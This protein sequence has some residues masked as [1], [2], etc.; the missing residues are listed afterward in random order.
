MIKNILVSLFAVALLALPAATASAA[1][2]APEVRYGTWVSNNNHLPVT[3]RDWSLYRNNV[4]VTGWTQYR[5]HW[6][7]FNNAGVMQ[8]GWQQLGG[9]W[10]FLW[11]QQDGQAP[12]G[13]ML[14]NDWLRVGTNTYYAFGANGVMLTGV[15]LLTNPFTGDFG[16]FFFNNDGAMQRGW[17]R[18]N[19]TD[20][21][22]FGGNGVRRSGIFQTSYGVSYLAP[23]G[24]LATG[25]TSF[26]GAWHYSLAN[27]RLQADRWVQTGGVWYRLVGFRMLANTAWTNA[28]NQTFF[29]AA[30]G[31]MRTGWVQAGSQWTWEA[32]AWIWPDD[33]LVLEGQWFYTNADGVMQTGWQQIGG[34]WFY[35]NRPEYTNS[36]WARGVMLTG[37]VMIYGRWHRFTTAGRWIGHFVHPNQ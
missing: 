26:D 31:A 28:N 8:T 21:S 10:F 6:Y 32:G 27:G 34:Q 25:W 13:A 33:R 12:F 14:A 19:G 15:H 18:P 37:D 3:E 4:R 11:N 17:Q 5:G 35:F 29:F 23:N 2:V 22:Y 16:H 7:F 30:N 20:W 9:N 36:P 24:I 1:P